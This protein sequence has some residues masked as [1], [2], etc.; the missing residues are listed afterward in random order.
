VLDRCEG[1]RRADDE[2]GLAGA[3]DPAGHRQ[4]AAVGRLGADG[5]VLGGEELLPPRR[6]PPAGDHAPGLLDLDVAADE[7]AQPLGVR[8][9]HD[10]GG[11]CGDTCGGEVLHPGA[12][13]G[14]GRGELPELARDVLGHGGVEE[15]ERVLGDEGRPAARAVLVPGH[16]PAPA[17]ARGRV[18]PCSSPCARRSVLSTSPSSCRAATT[19]TETL[20]F[21]PP[22]WTA[23][24]RRV[25]AA[26]CG[27][28]AA[29]TTSPISASDS[30]P[31]SPSLHRTS[32][33]EPPARS[34]Q[35]SISGTG[36][37]PTARVM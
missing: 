23:R 26:S 5:D 22:P 12:Q 33:S 29:A 7:D 10:E 24:S 11:Q 31:N 25:A 9:D 20:S 36:P 27:W 17:S 16:R 18:E 32:C 35:K 28:P 6:V 21:A 19:T 4:P 37:V 2:P 14:A 3:D 13:P 1:G 15:G 34:I 30:S 8:L